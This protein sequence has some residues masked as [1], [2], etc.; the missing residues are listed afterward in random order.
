[1]LGIPSALAFFFL[2]WEWM[3]LRFLRPPAPDQYKASG[4]QAVDLLV[5][6]FAL[7][8]KLLELLGGAVEW[9]LGV[10]VLLSLLCLSFAAL[11]FVTARGLNAGK[12]WARVCG[13]LLAFIV[14]LCSGFLSTIPKATPPA[15]ILAGGALY[16]LWVLGWRYAQ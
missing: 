5:F 13:L 4:N 7:I 16:V 2:S 1:M 3:S 10:L 14:L 9:M 8:G 15:L 12:T 11:L 6:S